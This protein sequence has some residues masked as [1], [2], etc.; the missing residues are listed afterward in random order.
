MTRRA[1]ALLIGL[2]FTGS[3]AS[4]FGCNSN[5]PGGQKLTNQPN[6]PAPVPPR[7]NVAL[8]P[9][10]RDAAVREIEQA[11]KSNDPVLRA[12]AVEAA[13]RGMHEDA[14]QIVMSGLNDEDPLVRFAAAMAAGELW[15]TDAMPRLYQMG[16]DPDRSVQVA[17]R[18]ALHRMGD[19][20]YSH[21][22][23]VYATDSDPQVRAN[24]AMALGLLGEPS[25]LK[26]L[27][28][29]ENDTNAAVRIQVAEARWRLGDEEGLDSLVAGT[30]SAFPDDQ[31][32]SILA[33]AA[34]HDSRVKEHIEGK[35]TSDYNEI[36]LAAARAMGQL[37]SDAGYGVAMNGAKSV[38]PRLKGMAAMA[39]GDIGRRDAQDQLG[40]LLKDSDKNVRLAAATAILELK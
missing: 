36:A 4:T 2:L 8:N 6:P 32:V 22:L 10:L 5:K 38:D 21:D 17:V 29:M 7:R 14:K 34:T 18:F 40:R 15:L 23:E 24:T 20:R 39:L 25:A 9:S 26:I 13:Q 11:A 19:T 31:I 35:L 28:G 30:V 37:G 16:F 12:N 3:L 1:L 33:L 27:R